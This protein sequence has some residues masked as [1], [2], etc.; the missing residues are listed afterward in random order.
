MTFHRSAQM[1]PLLYRQL[2][3]AVERKSELA[4]CLQGHGA[5]T[6]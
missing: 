4:S 6:A 2:H 5:A 1:K 3:A